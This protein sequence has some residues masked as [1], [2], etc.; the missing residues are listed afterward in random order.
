MQPHSPARV[1]QIH[2]TRR[3]NL[4]CL[5]CYSSSGPT[6]REALDPDAVVAALPDARALGYTLATLSG[7]EPFL[8]AAMGRVLGA[9]KATGLRTAAVTNGMFL[10]ERRLDRLGGA[11][12]LC[13]VSLDGAPE[14]HNRMRNHPKAF[15]IMHTKLQA[16]RDSG[17]PFGFLFTLAR[18]NVD[19]I[20]WAAKFAHEEGA[21]LLQIHPLDDV[22]RAGED[23]A[24][25]DMVPD[26]QVGLEAAR[27]AVEIK[28]RYEGRLRVVVDYQPTRVPAREGC[29]RAPTFA[30]TIGTLCIE[31][32]GTV[33]PAGHGFG[34]RF[35]LGRLGDAP[36]AEL[37]RRYDTTG[38]A[39][40]LARF[41]EQTRDRVTGKDAPPL[42]NLAKEYRNAS[43]AGAST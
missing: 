10:D 3:C 33:V 22:G 36:L 9:A 37:A 26:W 43:F 31:T 19:E 42:V 6:A 8:Y 34:R 13:V 5:H 15:E 24:V 27:I 2:V 28:R 23:Q 16:L 38:R 25:R 40:S 32:D 21:R 35:V 41:I 7:G 1:L 17:I 12:D 18:D 29:G 4:T 20:E 14:R 39:A 11:L 30:D